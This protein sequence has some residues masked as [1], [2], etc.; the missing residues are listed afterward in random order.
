V[1]RHDWIALALIATLLLIW[2]GMHLAAASRRIDRL[3]DDIRRR[4]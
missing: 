3:A 4:R 1:T 2:A